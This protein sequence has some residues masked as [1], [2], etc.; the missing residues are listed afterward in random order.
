[1]KIIMK[2]IFKLDS[3]PGGNN[4]QPAVLKFKNYLQDNG[5]RDSIIEGYVFRVKNY[6]QFAR[7][8]RYSPRESS[9]PNQLHLPFALHT[10]E[11]H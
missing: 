10:C 2:L 3:P 7:T 9:L 11:Q 4:I 5:Y 6:M 8:S 1:M